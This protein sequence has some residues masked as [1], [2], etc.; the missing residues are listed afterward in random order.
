[1]EASPAS[2]ILNTVGNTPADNLTTISIVIP[3]PQDSKPLSKSPS[4][5]APLTTST[6]SGSDI[7]LTDTEK[8][9]PKRKRNRSDSFNDVSLEA[10]QKL[11]ASMAKAN[12]IRLF[13]YKVYILV[14]NTLFILFHVDGIKISHNYNKWV[15]KMGLKL[16]HLFTYKNICGY[17]KQ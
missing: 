9:L 7:P 6:S 17:N 8:P 14:S 1:M 3:S 11:N 12:I 2:D 15:M 16:C 4:I 5:I 10:V 13:C